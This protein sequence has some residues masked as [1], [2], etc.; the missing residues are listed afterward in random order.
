MKAAVHANHEHQL[1]DSDQTSAHRNA[2][3]LP[4]LKWAGGKRRLVP[5]LHRLLPRAWGGYF[6]PFLGSG[7]LYFSMPQSGA[8]L[9][10]ANEELICCYEVVRDQPEKLISRLRQHVYSREHYAAVRRLRPED[11]TE[12]ERASRFVFLNRTCFNGL[13][14]V[15]RRGE[16]N[17]PMGRYTNPRLVPDVQIR[18][19]SE[20]L[21][22]C[23]LSADPFEAAVYGCQAGDLVYL[24]P[25]YVPTAKYSDFDRYHRLC[26]GEEDQ[27]RLAVL[28]AELH[29][30]GCLVM[31]SNSDAP[32]VRELYQQWWFTSVQAT[33]SISCV[34][35][36]RGKVAEVIVTNYA[37][38]HV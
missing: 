8:H 5:T 12:V 13:W 2:A 38:S 7:A 9:N 33:R 28:F 29:E 18:A 11:L 4:F 32:L 22:S 10:D 19:A 17:T 26:F 14:R 37:P 20:A 27:Q 1:P 21:R 16:F 25:P 34:G 36:G 30:R 3:T 15:N 31:L 6:E 24:D 35:Q 23:H